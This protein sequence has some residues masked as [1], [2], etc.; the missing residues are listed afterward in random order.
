MRL[1]LT[2]LLSVI[3]VPAMAQQFGGAK[4]MTVFGY[5]NPVDSVGLHAS[6]WGYVD[7]GGREYGFL[8]SQI[9][10]HIIDVTTAPI[11]QV[12]FIPG[13]TNSWR[14]MKTYRDYLYIASEAK[15][16]GGG[17]QIVSLANLPASASLVR[18]DTTNFKSIHT[19]FIRDHYLYAMGTSQDAGANGGVIIV[20][21][22][23]DPLHPRKVGRID[24]DY[25]HDAWVRNDT[26]V[27]AA[28]YG[29]GI[30][31]FNIVD[32]A[33]PVHLANINYPYS[34]THNVEI[35]EN[36]YLVSSD[37]IGFTQKTMKVWDITDLQNVRMTAERTHNLLDIVHNVHVIGRYVFAAWYTGGVRIIDMVDPAHPREVAYYDTYPGQGGGYNGAWET[38]G[39]LPSGK[40]LVG[41]RQ[42]G[43]YVLNWDRKIGASL[44]GV[45]R[46]ANS[47]LR[48]RG[49]ALRVPEHDTTYYSGSDGRYYIGGAV[50]DNITIVAQ[51][52]GYAGRT[53]SA[54]LVG[55]ETRDISLS[56]LMFVGASISVVDE[57]GAPIDG[58]SFAVE[59]HMKSRTAIGSTE[60][61]SLPKDSTYTLTVGKW[62]Y[63]A[64]ELPVTLSVDNGTITVTLER[65]YHDNSTLDLGWQ[66]F[67]PG[68][69]AQTG[70]WV[71]IMTYLGY[72]G[73]GWIHPATQPDGRVGHVF[74]TGAPPM[75]ALP[76]QN[77][78]NGGT[79]SLITPLMDLRDY[80]DPILMFDQWFVHYL[81]ARTDT[82]LAVDSL[83][84]DVSNDDG[85][86]WY[87]MSSEAVGRGSW[88]PRTIPLRSFAPLSDRMRIR[89]QAR[90]LDEVTVFYVAIDNFEI[91]RFDASSVDHGVDRDAI[92]LRVAPN[93]ATDA[94][95]AMIDLN[96]GG[97]I[98]VEL[99]NAIGE[100]VATLFDG[101]AGTSL[102]LA[103][104]ALSTG[105]Y[106]LHVSGSEAASLPF[107]VVR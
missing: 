25:Y 57:Q 100:R 94:S 56:P 54:K 10:T 15:G 69:D 4:N 98:R 40:V 70:Q 20:D 77:D 6:I 3:A 101:V 65:R 61:L 11:R 74:M 87:R 29:G 89:F 39:W 88:Q 46:D 2:L 48:L 92:S 96:R 8:G 16:E 71:R 78:V 68:D 33:N 23:P 47:G 38:Y 35:T 49:V 41:D 53:E 34:G 79:T 42:S 36:G 95:T 52:F 104:P 97:R 28:V 12:A 31:I 73:S 76:Q 26:L 30:D 21:L 67:G 80:P 91:A 93:P 9:G 24:R 18:T 66:L 14:E 13:P 81:N 22:E 103:L 45:V 63:R 84:V 83:T 82:T 7:P 75:F 43:M 32:K 17:L 99:F 64:K 72:P 27:A 86:T 50:D 60:A 58:F 59:P 107:A 5:L 90:D 55:D 102:R 19:L 44:S 106:V 51:Q 85:Q 62:G 1:L 37:E 105:S